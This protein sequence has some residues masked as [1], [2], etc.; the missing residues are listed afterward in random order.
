[1]WVSPFWS[2]AK[3]SVFDASGLPLRMGHPLDRTLLL[4]LSLHPGVSR[5]QYFLFSHGSGY[6]WSLYR[7]QI[8]TYTR[9][10]DCK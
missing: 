9:G 4:S 8:E 10:F 5:C 3:T 7:F 1:M 6:P 2:I